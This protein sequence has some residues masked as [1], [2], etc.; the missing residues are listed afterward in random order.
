LNKGIIY[1]NHIKQGLE[2]LKINPSICEYR[3]E[4][5]LKPFKPSL[6]DFKPMR[7]YNPYNF[8]LAA[9]RKHG[10]SDPQAAYTKPIQ[11]RTPVLWAGVRGS[12]EAEDLEAYNCHISAT[13][14]ICHISKI[15]EGLY[16]HGCLVGWSGKG[17]GR[18]RDKMLVIL[19][20]N[21]HRISKCYISIDRIS[22]VSPLYKVVMCLCEVILYRVC[23]MCLSD[24]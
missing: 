7:V 22:F 19:P 17:A 18:R 4:S 24:C 23:I 14:Q 2:A 10:S 8:I 3:L 9:S 5:V 16:S 6:S 21:S 12:L 11:S 13:S 20:Y 1:P 15:V